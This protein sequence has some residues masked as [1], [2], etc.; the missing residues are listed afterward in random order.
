MKNRSLKCLV[1]ACCL[2]LAASAVCLG[3][4]RSSNKLNAGRGRSNRRSLMRMT[5]WRLDVRS[6]GEYSG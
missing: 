1:A 2:T 3:Q 4:D 6:S 5:W